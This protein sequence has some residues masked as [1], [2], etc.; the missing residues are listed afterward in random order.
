VAVGIFL[1]HVRLLAKLGYRRLVEKWLL[2]LYVAGPGGLSA[3]AR[4]NLERIC[5]EHVKTGYRIDVI[6]LLKHPTLAREHEVVAVPMVV[7]ESPVPIRKV[8]GDLS[9]AERALFALK[10]G[11]YD[12]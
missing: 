4:T 1:A 3:L 6:D 5:R 8:I 11:S 10:L 9:N 7:R 2:R 12:V